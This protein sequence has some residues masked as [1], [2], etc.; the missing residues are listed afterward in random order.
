M[1]GHPVVSRDEWTAKRKELLRK[2]KEL[3]RLH[4]QLNAE[5]QA[6][7]WVKLEKDYV[8]DSSSGKVTLSELFEGRN[9]LIVHH[10]MLGPGW[11][12]GCVGCSFHADH[13]DGALIHLL[14]HDVNYV[15]VS[16]A[17]L[18]EIEA[19]NRRMGWHARWVSSYQS[20]FNYD[21]HVSFSEADRVRGK[22]YY[23]FTESDFFSEEL[24]GVSVFYQDEAGS[25]FH[26]YSTHARGEEG[27]VG[28]Y[29]YLDLTPLGR[30]ETGPYQNLGDWVRHHDRYGASGHVDPTG[31]YVAEEKAEAC[32]H[33]LETSS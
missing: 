12:E 20:D 14:N 1:K 31:R 30:N 16:R 10:F 9:Q 24:S 4:D 2:E 8:F 29:F 17:P 32:C 22:A 28:T 7:P 13:A 19:F 6:L 5:R 33:S 26:T 23:N 3:T 15:R 25:L 27:I 18:S 21:F 11:K